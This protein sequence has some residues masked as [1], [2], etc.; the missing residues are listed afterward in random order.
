VAYGLWPGP[1][2]RGHPHASNEVALSRGLGPLVGD[3]LGP[4]LQ[5]F[6]V[7]G[8]CCWHAIAAAAVREL[9]AV[10]PVTHADAVPMHPVH[11][12]EPRRASAARP[13]QA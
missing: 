4:L 11:F 13:E 8:E 1:K 9:R 6:G 12:G 7:R 5:D 3:V 2:V 10:G